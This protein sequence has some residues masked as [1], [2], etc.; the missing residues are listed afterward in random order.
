MCG[1]GFNE[2]ILCYSRERRQLPLQ[3]DGSAP[4]DAGPLGSPEARSR[5]V[6]VLEALRHVVAEETR[7]GL[8]E[9][10]SAVH[11]S[12]IFTNRTKEID[13]KSDRIP[14]VFNCGNS[15]QRRSQQENVVET[16]DTKCW[17]VDGIVSFSG[18]VGFGE[19]TIRSCTA[20]EPEICIGA[21]FIAANDVEKGIRILPL[22]FRFALSGNAVKLSED[23]SLEVD[24]PGRVEDHSHVGT[25]E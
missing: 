11:V 3:F 19:D 23:I 22:S 1:T 15:S 13:G 12:A 8:R 14:L 4:K 5:K 2:N 16:E 9:R 17:D 10:Y 6:D 24:E 21:G 25:R 20:G 7:L 18:T